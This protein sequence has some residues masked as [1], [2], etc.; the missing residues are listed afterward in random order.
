MRKIFFLIVSFLMLAWNMPAQVFTFNLGVSSG[1]SSPEGFFTHDTGGKWNFN[2]KFNGG[3]YAGITFEQGLKMEGSTKILFT[4]TKVSTVTIVQ[5]TR[6]AN[7]INLDETEL[8]VEDAVDGTGCRIYTITDV[9]AGAHSITRGSG[10]S[11]LFYVKVE[12]AGGDTP[13]DYS[14]SF[15]TDGGWSEVY[16]YV[17]R[18]DDKKALGE[19]PG[20]LMTADGDIYT[21]AFTADQIPY[22]IT[23]HDNNGH[24]TPEYAF[25]NGK[26]YEYMMFDYSATF[27]TNAGWEEVYAY[28]FQKTGD[29]K[30]ELLGAWPGTKMANGSPYSIDFKSFETPT[31]ICFNNGGEAKTGNLE[32]CNG[33]NYRYTVSTREPVF[34]V[35]EGDTF[36]S[37]VFIK[38]EDQGET[39]AYLTCGVDGDPDF[40]AASAGSNEDN[41]LYTAYTAG[42]GVNGGE[43]VGTCYTISP[44]FDG[45]ISIAVMLKANKK[46]YILEDGSVMPGY[47]GLQN[48]CTGNGCYDFPVK[49]GSTYMIYATGS[50][51]GFFGFDFVI[52]STEATLYV[53]PDGTELTIRYDQQSAAFA[54]AF[55]LEDIT[56]GIKDATTKVILH[57]SL[58][59]YEPATLANLFSSMVKLEEIKGLD[60]INTSLLTDVSFMFQNCKSLTEINLNGFDIK[61]VSAAF[62]MFQ[63]CGELTTIVCDSDYTH[64]AGMISFAMFDGCN[65]LVGG[66]ETHWSNSHIDAEYARPDEGIEKPGYFT[67]APQEQTGIEDVQSGK[68]QSTKVL[69]NGQFFILRGDHIFDAQGKMVK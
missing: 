49:A 10:E 27:N 63:G 26:T 38:V 60:N 6:S 39:V 58:K 68:V 5:S 65:K 54:D 28:A 14:V 53:V 64:L 42:N 69:I 55:L 44:L 35:K 3:E 29:E 41:S 2:S 67:L 48:E 23:F 46:M 15:R 57:E 30:T 61:N 45:V 52:N 11:G 19:W 34:T 59:D 13:Q 1:V 8:A 25:E 9:A 36:Q 33:K 24:Q 12:Y 50:K 4:T 66:K 31:H 7:T 32:F 47:D 40:Y 51:L 20:T 21:I 17:R 18:D 16:A 43:G 37:G 56:S 62:G 22:Y